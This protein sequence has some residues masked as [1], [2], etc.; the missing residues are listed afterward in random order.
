MVFS[1]YF[2]ELF[3]RW[4]KVDGG[5]SISRLVLL[6]RYPFLS[7]SYSAGHGPSWTVCVKYPGKVPYLR[8]AQV[9]EITEQRRGLHATGDA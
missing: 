4:E 2:T 9:L 5:R 8:R 3:L 1:F 6:A 7:P